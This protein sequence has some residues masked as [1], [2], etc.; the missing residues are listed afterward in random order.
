MQDFHNNC[1]DLFIW[2]KAEDGWRKGHRHIWSR[3][4]LKRFA[5]ETPDYVLFIKFTALV[6]AD[7][8]WAAHCI[9]TYKVMSYIWLFQVHILKLF[10]CIRTFFAVFGFS[11][12]LK[13]HIYC[14][15]HHLGT[16]WQQLLRLWSLFFLTYFWSRAG[17]QVSFYVFSCDHNRTN[18]IYQRTLMKL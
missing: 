11:D 16:R 18:G 5:Y 8:Q 13:T 1:R 17:Y 14:N 9:L 2:R 15:I 10:L 6:M 7:V 3:D 12:F 4:M